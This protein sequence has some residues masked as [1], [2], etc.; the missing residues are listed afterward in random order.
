MG[1]G[2]G[3]QEPQAFT[4]RNGTQ[5]NLSIP[6]A[7]ASD[8]LDITNQ[9]KIVG[10]YTDAQGATHGFLLDGHTLTTLDIPFDIPPTLTIDFGPPIGV[11][12]FVRSSVP[13]M[14]QIEGINEPGELIAFVQN[15]YESTDP[16][17]PVEFSYVDWYTGQRV[18]SGPQSATGGSKVV[19]PVNARVQG[20]T[21]VVRS[22]GPL[23]GQSMKALKLD[24]GAT[25]LLKPH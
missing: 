8:A 23:R 11:V 14:T 2:Y 24:D 1:T 19:G 6:G 16:D 18:P 7:T 13:T 22:R 4:L 17:F 20:M 21:D 10:D 3:D 5:T 25:V 9:G 12:T 15:L